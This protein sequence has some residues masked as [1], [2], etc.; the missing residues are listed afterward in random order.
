MHAQHTFTHNLSNICRHTHT[1][2]KKLKLHF[3]SDNYRGFFFYTVNP[4]LLQL[5]F[6]NTYTRTRSHTHNQTHCH[7]KLDYISAHK[8]NLTQTPKKPHTHTP[9][10]LWGTLVKCEVVM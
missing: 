10:L 6:T 4:L 9:T 1:R 5:R 3:A 8:K 2:T 7:T